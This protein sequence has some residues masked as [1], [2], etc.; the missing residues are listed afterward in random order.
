MDLFVC[1]P[2]TGIHNSE[3]YPTKGTD[4]TT[5]ERESFC[6]RS[7]RL[8]RQSADLDLL[9]Q[10]HD[11]IAGRPASVLSGGGD[12]ATMYA[13]GVLKWWRV[14]PRPAVFFP[15]LLTTL[16]P[17]FHLSFFR[18]SLRHSQWAQMLISRLL[19]KAQK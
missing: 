16:D 18:V 11:M 7:N 2:Q 17:F 3:L 6:A 12:D 13:L 10:Y 4:L 14:A 15:P 9:P 19:P 5:H 1:Q 8:A